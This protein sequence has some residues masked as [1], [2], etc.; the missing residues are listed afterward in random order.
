MEQVCWQQADIR[1]RSHG[2]Q[3][4]YTARNAQ[5]VTGLLQTLLQLVHL[6]NQV[7]T[8]RMQVVNNLLQVVLIRPDA[9]C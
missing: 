5:A 6:L 1:M 4:L 2:L 8:G 7:E 9:S 3:Q